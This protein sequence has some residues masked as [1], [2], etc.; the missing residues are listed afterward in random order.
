MT[1]IALYT[2]LRKTSANDFIDKLI[3]VCKKNGIAYIAD[4]TWQQMMVLFD[5]GLAVFR[6]EEYI[7]KEEKYI[8]VTIIPIAEK[9]SLSIV[10]IDV[11][12][13]LKEM[14][15]D[16]ENLGFLMQ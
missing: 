13:L 5:Y 11:L 12:K 16:Y 3:N 2:S 4:R 10:I 7:K 1:K 8:D 14:G 15:M 9:A 6:I